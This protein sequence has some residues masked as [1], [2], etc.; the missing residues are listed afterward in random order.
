MQSIK[1]QNLIISFS[2]MYFA[3]LHISPNNIDT[4]AII[5]EVSK[6]AD[7]DNFDIYRHQPFDHL[8]GSFSSERKPGS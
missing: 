6:T 2:E 3:P 5:A 1:R 7:L 8:Y 4:N